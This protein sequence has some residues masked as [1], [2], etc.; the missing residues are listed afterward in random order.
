MLLPRAFKC[1]CVLILTVLYASINADP[2]CSDHSQCKFVVITGGVISGI[3]K[4][5]TASSIGLILKM[6]KLRPTAIKVGEGRM[7][8]MEE[9]LYVSMY[10]Y[11]YACINVS[12]YLT[13]H[14]CMYVCNLSV[15]CV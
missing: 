6:M 8:W 10:L 15:K 1:Y 7:G 3:G 5:V 11:L 12:M 14:V 9:F 4:G 2:S 13:V